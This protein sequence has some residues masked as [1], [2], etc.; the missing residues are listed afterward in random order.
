MFNKL[1]FFIVIL[2]FITVFSINTCFCSDTTYVWSEESIQI[3]TNAE[4]DQNE[5][6]DNFL[7]ITSGSAVLIEQDSRSSTI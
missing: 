1:K 2:V 3:P 5:N 6:S 7:N 4:T